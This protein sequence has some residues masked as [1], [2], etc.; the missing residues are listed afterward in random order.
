[1]FDGDNN[2]TV[3]Y[4]PWT[5]GWGS[6]YG[7]LPTAVWNPVEWLIAL[8]DDS[9]V[10]NPKPLMATL[11]AALASIERGNFLA[12]ANQLNAFQNKVRAQVADPALASQF[13][14][15]AQQVIDALPVSR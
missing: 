14:E 2:A 5:T 9:A 13:I 12:A 8:V 3:Y 4:L 1:V 6:T 10:G 11:S 15:A 7:G